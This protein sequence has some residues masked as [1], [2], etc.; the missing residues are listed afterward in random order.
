M[1]LSPLLAAIDRDDLPVLCELLDDV[2][3][4]RLAGPEGTVLLSTAAYAGRDELVDGLV[5]AGADV[6]QP[7][8]GGVD[9]VEWAARGG[10]Y[11]T[12]T[13]LLCGLPSSAVDG[14]RRR[15]LELA[16]AETA[17]AAPGLP[18]PGLWA[19][20]TSAEE[21]LGVRLDPD[22]LLARALVHGNPDGDDWFADARGLAA[23]E[24]AAREVTGPHRPGAMQLD[25]IRRMLAARTVR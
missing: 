2:P 25:A 14:P 20:V 15:A 22:E 6:L 3:R 13:Y 24:A 1:D 5:Q 9:P 19:V 7:W 11:W 4:S 17:A 18:R 8:P 21:E 10:R 12:L 16:Q 23:L